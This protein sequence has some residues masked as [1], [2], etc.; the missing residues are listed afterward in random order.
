VVARALHERGLA[1]I[2]AVEPPYATR[3]AMGLAEHLFGWVLMP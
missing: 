1:Q 3:V 2:E